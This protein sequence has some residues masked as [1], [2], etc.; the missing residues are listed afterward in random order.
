M[1]LLFKEFRY[2]FLEE[3]EFCPSIVEKENVL[4]KKTDFQKEFSFLSGKV[5]ASPGG[6]KKKTGNL[7]NKAKKVRP[8]L[9]IVRIPAYFM[10]KLEKENGKS[11]R[12][13][14]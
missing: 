7:W 4:R 10:K 13:K 11:K 5:K 3:K 1:N 9:S 8:P 12:G 2:V 14:K 6:M